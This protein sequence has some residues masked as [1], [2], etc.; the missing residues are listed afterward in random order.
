MPKLLIWSTEDSDV[1]FTGLEQIMS[2]VPDIQLFKI[3]GSEH[4]IIYSHANK[5]NSGIIDF[6]KN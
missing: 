2:L 1:H 4:S 6:L 5:I 3:E